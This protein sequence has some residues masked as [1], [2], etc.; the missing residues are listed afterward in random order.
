MEF[1]N[2]SVQRRLR[3]APFYLVLGLATAITLVPI[4]WVFASALK[5]NKE[6]RENALALPQEWRFQNYID[7]WF[8]ASFDQYFFNSIL[9]SVTSVAIVLL[10]SSLAAYSFAKMRFRGNQLIFFVFL[11]GMAFPLSAK[12]GPLL[13]LMYKLDLANSRVGLILV[14]VAGSLPFSI[15]MLRAFFAGFPQELEDSAALDGCS[16]FQ[17][18]LRIL[19]PLSKP[20]LMALGIFV[21][22]NTWNEF[23]QALL[24]INE[25]SKRTLPLGLTAFQDEYFTDF[26]LSFAGINIT[27]LPVIVVYIIFQRNLIEGITVGSMK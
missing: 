13:S 6:I 23:F 7:A 9:V 18:Y 19:L 10:L 5:S 12:L 21:F 16:R 25:D 26:A 17:F 27:A 2:S 1:V 14:Y 15:L 3:S 4:I 24:L 20:S 22:M 11:I 8:G